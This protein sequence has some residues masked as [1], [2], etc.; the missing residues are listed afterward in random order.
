MKSRKNLG[1]LIFLFCLY[2][3]SIAD[4]GFG[5][6]GVGTLS[7]MMG[8]LNILNPVSSSFWTVEENQ[9][10][11]WN[12][13]YVYVVKIEYKVGN[14]Q[15]IE[16]ADSVNASS[17]NYTWNIPN[18]TSNHCRIRITDLKNPNVFSESNEFI[19]K[20]YH[21]TRMSGDTLEIFDIKKHTWKFGN[22]EGVNYSLSW[23][24]CD[25]YAIMWPEEWWAQF[26]Y[27]DILKYHHYKMWEAD[28]W[29]FPDWDL[30]ANTFGDDACY[31][32]IG[33]IKFFSDY[34][35]NL[36][37]TI[38]EIW[39]G[40]CAGFAISALL[41]YNDKDEFLQQNNSLEIFADLRDFQVFNDD[42]RKTINKYYH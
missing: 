26:N 4:T 16:I 10:I 12:S 6:S 40:S 25:K 18:E 41:A 9:Q 36:W 23:P 39:G 34:A 15:W 38:N 17:G 24:D 42:I 20:G 21:L 28:S 14:G 32:Y 3:Q 8:N 22:P 35:V 37:F 2:A 7:S 31:F 29:E 11:T 5:I 1:L 13:S 33:P 19:L 30:F 27:L